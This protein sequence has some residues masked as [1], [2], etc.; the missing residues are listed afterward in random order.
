MLAV[1]YVH[2][3]EKAT[4]LNDEYQVVLMFSRTRTSRSF[5][6]ETQD[7]DPRPTNSIL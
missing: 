6:N 5:G 1:I 3:Y 4:N 2:A 7:K